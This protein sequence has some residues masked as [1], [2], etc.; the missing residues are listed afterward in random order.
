MTQAS[1]RRRSPERAP[2]LFRPPVE[3]ASRHGLKVFLILAGVLFALMLAM[4][5]FA[6]GVPAL[7]TAPPV[8]GAGDAIDRAL[9]MPRVEREAMLDRAQA[10]VTAEYAQPHIVARLATELAA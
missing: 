6:Q 4:P 1:L 9:A 2:A 10:F 8:P 3:P 5:A 7:P